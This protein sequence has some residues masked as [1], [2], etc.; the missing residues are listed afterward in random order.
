[1]LR[2]ALG[3]TKRFDLWTSILNSFNANSSKSNPH[4][5]R[6]N[7]A[8]SIVAKLVVADST[9]LPIFERL[10]AEIEAMASNAGAIARAQAIANGQTATF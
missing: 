1:V 7:N 3:E 8:L 2:E 10:E 5:H 9:Y 6:L 4:H